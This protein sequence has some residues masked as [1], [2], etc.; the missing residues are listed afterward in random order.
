MPD[1][2]FFIK[3]D[4]KTGE[5]VSTIPYDQDVS[6]EKAEQL[7]TD[8]YEL[9]PYDDWNLLIGNVDGQEYV[10]D[11]VRG[12][13][14]VK[15]PTTPTL[16]E[17]KAAKIADLKDVRNTKELEPLN[18][19][20]VDERSI[21]RLQIAQDVLSRSGQSIDWTM[22]DNSVQAISADDIA[23]VFAALAIRSATL[24]ETYR[25]LKAAVMAAVA[26]DDVDAIHWPE[27]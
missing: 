15:P 2:M 26:N 21:T 17:A 7:L 23:A 16:E 1:T 13:Y 11:F 8:G 5:R 20:D 27:A 22:A 9:V 6:P 3:F 12:G 18:N 25:G 19:F 24:H 4:P 10:K 14:K